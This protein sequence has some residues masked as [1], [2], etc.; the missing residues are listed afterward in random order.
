MYSGCFVGS[1]GAGICGPIGVAFGVSG[2]LAVSEPSASIPMFC[3]GSAIGGD[4]AASAATVNGF[5]TSLATLKM[6]SYFDAT[7]TLGS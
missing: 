2:E 1:G 4:R 6:T 7:S 5:L 3:V